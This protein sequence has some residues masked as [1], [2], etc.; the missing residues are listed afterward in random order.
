MLKEIE[1]LSTCILFQPNNAVIIVHCR[2]LLFTGKKSI[3][4]ISRTVIKNNKPLPG[5]LIYWRIILLAERLSSKF[6]SYPQSFRFSANFFFCRTIFQ[7]WALSSNIPLPDGTYLLILFH[8]S[9]M[10]LFIHHYDSS[11]SQ[12]SL[13][14]NQSIEIHQHI[15]TNT[16]SSKKQI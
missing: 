9:Y 5:L 16:T 4:E 1:N 11:C 12:T 7:P 6:R 8:S 2:F 14:L 13:C 10:Y 15:F 3:K